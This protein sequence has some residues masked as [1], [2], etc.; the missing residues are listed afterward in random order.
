MATRTQSRH[1]ARRRSIVLAI[2]G[3][4]GGLGKS[5]ISIQLAGEA[6]E[7]GQD[8]LLVDTDPLMRTAEKWGNAA[9]E[10]KVEAPRIVAMSRSLFVQLPPLAAKHDITIIDCP[11]RGG[12]ETRAAFMVAD[13]VVLPIGPDPSEFWGMEPTVT[14]AVN[15]RVARPHL[16]LA[17]LLNQM[18]M[19]ETLSAQAREDLLKLNLDPQR[20]DPPTT[21]HDLDIPILRTTI[22]DRIDFRKSQSVGMCAATYAP[23]TQAADEIRSLYD[24]LMRLCGGRR[25]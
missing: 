7:R 14:L 12:D 8:V 16:P 4:K 1:G 2:A 15:A 6:R 3:L 10:N 17:V 19:Q 5:L 18:K 24:E 21:L 23:N 11:G 20:Q 25:G 13:L 9:A 22:G